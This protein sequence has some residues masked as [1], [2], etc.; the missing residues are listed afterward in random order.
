MRVNWPASTVVSPMVGR[1]QRELL[2]VMLLRANQVVSVDLLTG[3]TARSDPGSAPGS[4]QPSALV[5]VR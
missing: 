3:D 1:R 5:H 2:A 4:D